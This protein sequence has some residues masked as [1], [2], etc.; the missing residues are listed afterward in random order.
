VSGIFIYRMAGG[1]DDAL[2]DLSRR[3]AMNMGAKTDVMGKFILRW[4]TGLACQRKSTILTYGQKL[5]RVEKNNAKL[6]LL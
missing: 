5:H 4:T 2:A 6:C 3:N 1:A